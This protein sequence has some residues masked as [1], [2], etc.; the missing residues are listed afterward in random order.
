[1][2]RALVFDLDDT[3]YPERRFALSGYAAVSAHVAARYDVSRSRAFGL[4]R[5]ELVAGRRAQSFQVLADRLHLPETI[6]FEWRDIYRDHEPQLR[7]PAATRAVLSAARASWKLAVLTNGIP[8]IQ[9]RKVAVLGL[10]SLVDA[11]IYAH[12]IGEGKPDPAVFLAACSAVDVPAGASVMTG[13]NPWCDVDGARRAGL[14]AIR[15]RRGL[16]AAVAE[17]ET[18]PAD[19]T[20][21]HIG[22]V[23]WHA[24]RLLRARA[25]HAN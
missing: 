21:R 19:V 10:S 3:L 4:L 17:G 15:I 25:S 5:R 7:L 16:H 6:V 14:R 11:V 18:G 13:D 8:A 9:R 2:N 24:E 20:V 22:E 1:V 12:E 23:P